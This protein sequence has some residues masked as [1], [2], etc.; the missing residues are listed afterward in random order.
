M[1]QTESSQILLTDMSKCLPSEALTRIPKQGCWEMVDYVMDDGKAGTGIYAVPL[2]EAVPLELPLNAS[3][4][5]KI[6]VGIQYTKHY[7]GFGS[8]I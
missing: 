7:T 1:L 3:G 4:R 5:Y 8:V 6:Y 2:E